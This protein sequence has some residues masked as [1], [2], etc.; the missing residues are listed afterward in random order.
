MK[1]KT[2]SAIGDYA[3][4]G[5]CRSAALISQSGSL[6][7]LCLPRFDSPSIF[8]ALL[9]NERGGRFAIRPR[10]AFTAT[11]R[12]VGHTN[13]LE[14]TFITETGR[15]RLTDLMPVASEVQKANQ[16]LPDHELLR[17][18]NCDEGA[19][20]VEIVFDPRPDY[21]RVVP[22][23]M[24]RSALTY[25]YEHGSQ[26]LGLT[27]D[28]DL[29]G[30][31]TLRAGEQRYFSMVF[32]HGYP[33]VLAP[34]GK[35]A[36]IRILR[37][38]DWWNSWVANCRYDGP[39]REEV[40]RSALTLKLLTYSPS[41]AIVAAPTTS[42][43]EKIG[44]VRNWDYRYCWIRDASLTVRALLDLGFRIE[45]EAYLSWLLHATRLTWP[46]L[47]ILYDVY[48][49]RH[50]PER[51]LTHLSGYRESKPVRI[52]NDAAKQLQLDTYGEVVDATFQYV[53]RGGQLDR[54]TGRMLVG[55]GQTV[56]RRWR[57]SDEGIWEP[58]G[59]RQRHTHSIA[60]C[61]V[62]LDRLIKLHEAGHI[63]VPLPLFEREKAA[64][65]QEVET[66]GYNSRIQ[67]YVSVLDGDGLD[68]SLLLLGLNG[69]TDP[70]ELRMRNTYARVRER[71][72]IDG[73][74][75]RYL[76]Q[77]GLPPGE[78]TFGICAFW[79]VELLARQ[80]E[81]QL[82]R[83]HFEQLLSFMN[84]VGLFA[85]EIDPES[86][87]ALGNFPQGFTHVGLINAAVALAEAS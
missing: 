52:G 8:A 87:A 11:R 18:L 36:D 34:L 43:P 28:A 70:R 44:G 68:A 83:K 21:G 45:G 33:A 78:G 9:D 79:A 75:Y 53:L 19:V 4:V 49:E 50:L 27:T 46:A 15:L 38:V 22:K 37:S 58:R 1:E 86:G 42:L 59:G 61:W 14:T 3:I 10:Q 57:D 2:W 64:I 69:Y 82:A 16:L 25:F 81:L 54:T 51:E 60:M 6:D 24:S 67:S 84:D 7:W 40:T 23:L 77:D 5:D 26:T 29:A 30:P 85:E 73:L 35:E 56:C 41:G 63:R 55:L 74:L 62:A 31:L 72:G 13:V 32:S 12:Y 76:G 39:Y 65:R 80:G 20:E 71:L 48:G 17:K 66:R 47:Q